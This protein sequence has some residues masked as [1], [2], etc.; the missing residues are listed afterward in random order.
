ME[1]VLDARE[2]R[3]TAGCRSGQMFVI[4]AIII[5]VGLIMLKNLL[6][7][8]STMEEKRSVESDMLDKQLKNIRGEF[9]YIA[10]IASLQADANAS[11]IAYL[12]NFSGFLRSDADIRILYLFAFANGTSQKYSIT[13]GNYLK[14]NINAT[15]NVTGSTSAGYYFGTINDETNITTAF[16]STA[17]TVNITLAYSY[18]NQNITERLPLSVS[19]NSVAGFFDITLEDGMTVRS[20]DVYNRSWT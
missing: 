17:G 14:D 5:L 7:V 13:I 11:G 20:K 9:R 19:G 10:G 18:R 16:Q 4:A 8:Y 1:K 6:A 15:V 12:S 3:K 2:K